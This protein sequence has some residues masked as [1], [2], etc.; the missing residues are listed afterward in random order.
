MKIIINDNNHVQ[1]RDHLHDV[2]KQKF[3]IWNHLPEPRSNTVEDANNADVQHT[4][5]F[6]AQCYKKYTTQC[7]KKKLERKMVSQIK[8]ISYGHY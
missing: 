2:C 3:I 8:N 5:L 6:N 4:S 7:Y 1:E